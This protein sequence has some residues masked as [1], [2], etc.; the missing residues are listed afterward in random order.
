MNK[1]AP[2]TGKSPPGGGE[3]SINQSGE[4]AKVRGQWAM[5]QAAKMQARADRYFATDDEL[6]LSAHVLLLTIAAF[7][8]L[9][10]LWASFATLDELT[11]GEGRVVPSSEV[12][13]IQSLE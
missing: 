1:A 4:W 10:I 3:A 9:F 11:R 6:P 5:E 12:Q 7:F 8:G 2:K 13:K